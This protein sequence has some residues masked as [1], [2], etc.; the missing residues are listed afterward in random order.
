MHRSKLTLSVRSLLIGLMT[1]SLV[2]CTSSQ[3]MKAAPVKPQLK[4]KTV[5][6]DVC[7]SRDDSIKLGFYILELE[8][9]Y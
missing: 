4:A 3:Q 7:F 9:G 5:N 6:T 8:R 2:A 1:I